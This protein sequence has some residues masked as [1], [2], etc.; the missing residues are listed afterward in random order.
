MVTS[1]EILINKQK[2]TVVL[3]LGEE[4]IEFKAEDLFNLLNVLSKAY[5]YIGPLKTGMKV[6][7]CIPEGGEHEYNDYVRDTIVESGS[8]MKKMNGVE[9]I[10]IED[11]ND[12]DGSGLIGVHFP[13]TPF[14]RKYYY[15]FVKHLKKV[16]D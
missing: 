9:G 15:V 3:S 10:L 13:N 6:R 2:N 8:K 1:S 12:I 4:K 5:S 11:G 7:L 16:E 14:R